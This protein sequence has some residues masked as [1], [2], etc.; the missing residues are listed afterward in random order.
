MD[1]EG[2]LLMIHDHFPSRVKSKEFHLSFKTWSIL[3][4]GLPSGMEN[5]AFSF[6][7]EENLKYQHLTL[8][9]NFISPTVSDLWRH[10][11]IM[12]ILQTAINTSYSLVTFFFF[13]VS[14]SAVTLHPVSL[15]HT[16]PHTLARNFSL[17]SATALSR[18]SCLST[19]PERAEES[20]LQTTAY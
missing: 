6:E 20:D 18:Q 11:L 3:Q 8:N 10:Q 17:S 15:P 16:L 5:S 7:L 4:L 14:L 1:P 12:G 9:S 19:H 13:R 2:E